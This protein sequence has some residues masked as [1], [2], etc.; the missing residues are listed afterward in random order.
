[1]RRA[2]Q[3]RPDFYFRFS[4]YACVR[5]ATVCRQLWR[6]SAHSRAVRRWRARGHSAGSA[7]ARQPD[8]RNTLVAPA[9]PCEEAFAAC[10]LVCAQTRCASIRNQ[11][12]ILVKLMMRATIGDASSL[13]V[14]P[15]NEVQFWTSVLFPLGAICDSAKTRPGSHW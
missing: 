15:K 5:L 14:D 9:A 7:A 6:S 12:I 3:P 10:A 2:N 4:G 11:W 1:M 13:K 8:S